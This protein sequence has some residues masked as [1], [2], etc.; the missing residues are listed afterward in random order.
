MAGRPAEWRGSGGKSRD[1]VHRRHHGRPGQPD[2]DQSPNTDH[3]VADHDFPF[4]DGFVNSRLDG[5][6]S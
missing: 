3:A 4:T 1:Q 6:K 5:A 2:T